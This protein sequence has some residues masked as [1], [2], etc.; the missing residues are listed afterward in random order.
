MCWVLKEYPLQKK[1]TSAE[2]LR[3]HCYLRPRTATG[4]AVIRVR[5]E[6][7]LAF[8]SFFEVIISLSSQTSR[9]AYSCTNNG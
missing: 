3:D 2:W 5:S 9:H 7:T 1:A 6:A 4:A 8:H